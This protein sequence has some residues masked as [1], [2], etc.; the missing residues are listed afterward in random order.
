MYA[1]L[2]EKF[3]N[4]TYVARTIKQKQESACKKFLLYAAVLLMAAVLVCLL[5]K[6]EAKAWM[7]T[8][9]VV[10]MVAFLPFCFLPHYAKSK[11][12]IF[13]GKVVRIDEK[14]EI[15]PEKNAERF[16]R[17]QE[18]ETDVCEIVVGIMG[19]NGEAQVLLLPPQYEKILAIGDTLVTHA[20][21]SY[22]AHVSNLT[23]GIC[24]HCGT[25]QSAE[26]ESCITCGADM[27]S[28]H[29]VK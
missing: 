6:F 21:L 18:R 29:T 5:G 25:M 22:P 15:V 16:S 2:F 13:E 14:R 12:K 23:T 4:D 1:K 10:A 19:E 28:L 9:L 7:I 17:F 20:A 24:M 11:Q 26:N 27:Y 8:L 3:K